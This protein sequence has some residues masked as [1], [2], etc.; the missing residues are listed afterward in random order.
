MKSFRTLELA[1]KL[2]QSCEQLKLPY[3]LKNQIL[4]SSSS[5]ALNLSEGRAK[6]SKKDQ[7]RFF[8][9][10]MG[11]L[12]ETM[13]GLILA[14][15]QKHRIFK[16]ADITMTEI[17]GSQP[18]SCSALQLSADKIVHLSSLHTFFFKL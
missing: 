5:V 12:R 2:Y 14:N 1:I 17:F 11:S 4:R 10:A 8:H 15:Y 3:H 9:I 16:L 13:T 18:A 7:L 6:N